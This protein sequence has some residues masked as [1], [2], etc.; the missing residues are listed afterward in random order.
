VK[1][2]QKNQ[3]QTRL[4]SNFSDNALL[5]TILRTIDMVLLPIAEQWAPH[6]QTKS[7]LKNNLNHRAR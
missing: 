7:T 2:A 5:E 6:G 4:V 1:N 3:A